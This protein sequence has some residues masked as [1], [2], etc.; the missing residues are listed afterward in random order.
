MRKIFLFSLMITHVFVQVR[1]GEIKSITSSLEIRDLIVNENEIIL[2]TSGGLAIYNQKLGD[3]IVITKDQ[4]LIDTDLKIV[5]KGP[6]GLIWIG[7]G[8]GVQVW[9]N[10][11][12]MIV[13][14][15]QLDIEDVAGFV[16]YKETIYGAIKN[17]GIWGTMEFIHSNDKVYYR[18]FYGRNDI[19]KIVDV[20]SFGDDLILLTDLGLL[21]GNP[22]KTHLIYW[23]NPYPEL[24]KLTIAMN[25]KD[26]ELVLVTSSAIYSAKIFE[27]P[28]PLVTNERDFQYIRSI[29]FKGPT[30]FVAITDSV[31]YKIGTDKFQKQF[32]DSDFSFSDIKIN[33]SNSIIGTNIGFAI[34]DGTTFSHFVRNE[35]IV[36]APQAIQH[37]GN[38]RWVMANEKGI[39]LTKWI[40]LSVMPLSLGFSSKLNLSRIPI[41][42]G[43]QISELLFHNN[44]IYLGLINSTSAGVASFNI[45]NGLK[46]DQ[47]FFPKE[48]TSEPKDVYFVSDMAIDTKDN[49]WV[50]SGNKLNLPIT[51]FNE[52]QSRHFSIEESGG[53][54][55]EKSESIAVDNFNRVWIASPSGLVMYKY[56]GNVMDP[57]AEVW[58]AETVDLGLVKRTPLDINVSSRNRLWIL[59][60]IGLIHKDL[61]VSENNPVNQTGPT[62]NNGDLY[63][64]FPSVVF[65]KY[66]RIRFDPRG[67]V[68]V[69]SQTDGIHVVTKSGEYWPGI[70]G[71]NTSNSNLLSNHVNDVT[72]DS[73]DG[74]AFIATDKGVSVVRI[75]F[76]AKNK[77]YNEVEIFPSPFRI[78]SQKPMTVTG[79]KDKSSLKIM[80]LNGQV[81]RTL[82]N[83]DVQGYQANWDGR[84]ESGKLVGT[85][86]YLIAI[87]DTKG[88][89]SFEKVAV[90]RE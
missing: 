13:D 49:L 65:N 72:F 73:E 25:Q 83:S 32:S 6:K 57:S 7:S 18:D 14:W 63:P 20:Q 80:T 2:A 21:S 36:N 64:Y 54:L 48:L 41:H 74:L 10:S 52:S 31:I 86:V 71:L 46:V 38:D 88:T 16:N 30:D 26:G 53:L 8:M 4:G 22:H 75:P 76:S 37:L 82:N 44:K 28:I 27:T 69:T 5:H 59:T 12:K 81:L 24:E 62:S 60:N 43:T 40:N 9:D 42:L 58:V 78:P 61:Q 34:F 68:W 67:N 50:T 39:S 87:Y 3:Y 70:N 55:S 15:F 84:N 89:F 56:N 33:G 45:S 79:L 1:V 35:P 19:G 23:D 66:S 51:V 90:I 77:S 29:A 85:G 47:L 17:D 11:N